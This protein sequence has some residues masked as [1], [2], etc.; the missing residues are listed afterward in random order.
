[1]EKA[2]AENATAETATAETA[3]GEKAAVERAK[4][5][6]DESQSCEFR[7]NG[8]VH[9]WNDA[10]AGA[11][12]STEEIAGAENAAEEIAGSKNSEKPESEINEETADVVDPDSTVGLS[13]VGALLSGIRPN[14]I[15]N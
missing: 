1:M 10:L 6:M 13:Q 12:K 11:E 3:T 14:K 2:A 9:E 5:S 4:V 7:K 15:T 8:W